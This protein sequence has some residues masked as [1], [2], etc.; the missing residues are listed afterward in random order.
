MSDTELLLECILT[1]HILNK[2][3]FEIINDKRLTEGQRIN[4]L[5]RMME[6]FIESIDL[7]ELI[8]LAL[9]GQANLP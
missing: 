1:N 6:G 4:Y 8:K 2:R 5:K 9:R 3:F 7:E